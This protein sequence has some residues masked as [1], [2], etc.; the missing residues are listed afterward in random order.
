[1]CVSCAE[2]N[3]L[4][5]AVLHDFL[6]CRENVD[7]GCRDCNFARFESDESGPPCD[8][9]SPRVEAAA[10][11]QFVASS[12]PLKADTT[13]EYY[14]VPV[15]LACIFAFFIAHC[16]LSVYEMTVDALLLCTCE[17]EKRQAGVGP[18]HGSMTVMVDEE[19]LLAIPE[20][21]QKSSE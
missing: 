9:A 1:M 21:I 7:F 3:Y 5:N 11:V 15:L 4:S 14:F 19:Y 18:L 12:L 13:T 2:F 6:S 16:F 8:L 17:A 20:F 10:L